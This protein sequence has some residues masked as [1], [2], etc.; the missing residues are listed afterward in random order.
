MSSAQAP[1]SDRQQADLPRPERAAL[2]ERIPGNRVAHGFFTRQGGVS[3]GLYRGLNVGIGSND[4]AARVR[5]NRELAARTLGVAPERLLTP[6]QVHSAD[7]VIATEAWPAERPKADAVVTA[8]PGLAIGVITADCGP[9][10]FAEPEAGVVGAAHAGWR[11]A[12]SGIIEATVGAME[13]LGARRERMVAVLGPTISR[14]NYEVGPEFHARF[15]QQDPTYAAY[16]A[17]SAQDG[18]KMFDLPGFIMDRLAAA[19]IEAA[20]L[21]HCTYA[22]EERYFSY[23]RTTHRGEPDYGRQVS[24]IALLE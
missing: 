1:V 4:D 18:R 13:G 11:G 3:E 9:I 2:I 5:V 16:F 20:R 24:A 19:G 15:L 8:T 14:E 22:D 12:L 17:G 21:G 10:L 23:R 6:Y 7:V